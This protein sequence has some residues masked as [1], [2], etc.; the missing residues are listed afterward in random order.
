MRERNRENRRLRAR[1]METTTR[2]NG[3]RERKR[4]RRGKGER[5]EDEKGDTFITRRRAT[6]KIERQVVFACG[7]L[8]GSR[9]ERGRGRQ[10]RCIEKTRLH[11]GGTRSRG[12]CK[13][14]GRERDT[15]LRGHTRRGIASRS[16]SMQ[17]KILQIRRAEPVTHAC[18]HKGY[19]DKKRERQ[20][21]RKKSAFF[22]QGRLLRS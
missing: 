21:A 9:G 20:P 22:G 13:L 2:G 11:V 14:K 5:K 3:K 19:I 1:W 18:A 10:E 6:G 8:P 4:R 16:F 7:S 12:E 15:R 17:N